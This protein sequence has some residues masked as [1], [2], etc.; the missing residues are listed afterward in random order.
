LKRLEETGV[1]R[2][3]T[4]KVADSGAETAIRAYMTI[5]LKPGNN[6]VDVI[7]RFRSIPEILNCDV[8]A[9]SIDL[10]LRICCPS[11]LALEGVRE[12]IGRIPGVA[13]VT[14]H[15]VLANQW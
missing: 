2:G 5:S 12:Q 1:I 11:T 9:G 14:T 8:L 6:C 10:I 4:V 3:Y 7:P 13:A 15:V